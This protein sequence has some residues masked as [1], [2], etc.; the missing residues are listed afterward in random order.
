MMSSSFDL[1]HCIDFLRNKNIHV[2]CN[3]S[4]HVNCW[5]FQGMNLWGT[6]IFL[7]PLLNSSS[8][9][10]LTR[11]PGFFHNVSTPSMSSQLPDV[12]KQSTCIRTSRE[13]I[14][15]QRFV[16]RLQI[17]FPQPLFCE[18]PLQASIDQIS[19]FLHYILLY[20]TS[21]NKHMLYLNPLLILDHWSC[22]LINDQ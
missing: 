1:L 6:Q 22:C 13:S 12:S 17:L 7:S 11:P 3:I 16:N 9:R 2:L 19:T 18:I 4:I 20:N 14:A 21:S 15:R 10:H 8:P 5:C